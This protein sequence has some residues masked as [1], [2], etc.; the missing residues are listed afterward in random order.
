MSIFTDH[1]DSDLFFL[2]TF[3]SAAVEHSYDD[4]LDDVSSDQLDDALYARNF[5]I[6]QSN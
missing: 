1:K 5:G 4:A 3:Y 2:D 6:I